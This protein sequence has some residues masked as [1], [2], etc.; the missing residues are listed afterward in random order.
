VRRSR[1]LLTSLLRIALLLATFLLIPIAVSLFA[2]DCS[3]GVKTLDDNALSYRPLPQLSPDHGYLLGL[4]D[5]ELTL[6]EFPAGEVNRTFRA[7]SKHKVVGIAWSPS[8]DVFAYHTEHSEPEGRG[9][10]YLAHLNGSTEKIS[11]LEPPDLGPREILWSPSGR[12]LFW[13]KP[14]SVYDRE[15]GELFVRSDIDDGFSF[16]RSPLFSG[17]ESQLA[18]TLFESAGPENLWILDLGS[19]NTRQVTDEGEGDY[20]FHWIDNTRLL[21]RTGAVGTGGG[22]ISGL[23]SINVETGDRTPVDVGSAVDLGPE[24]SPFRRL[25]IVEGISPDEGYVIGESRSPAGDESWIY[26]LDLAG[27]APEIILRGESPS[28]AYM[29]LHVLW[30]DTDEMILAVRRTVHDDAGNRSNDRYQM[31]AYTISS[32]AHLLIDGDAAMHPLCIVDG[33][34]YYLESDDMDLCSLRNIPAE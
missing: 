25:H 34:L 3:P 31:Y 26:S 15:T 29:L 22:H 5:G 17:N 24:T 12:Y 27:G 19:G 11:D 4:V 20:P 7:E 21:V 16:V 28:E 14:F 32:G 30:V 9:G 6:A 33:R 23:A 2:T 8:G 18:Y 10:I 1:A 13:D